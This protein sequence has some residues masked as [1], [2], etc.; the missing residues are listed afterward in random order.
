[1]ETRKDLKI[2]TCGCSREFRDEEEDVAVCGVV[3]VLLDEEAGVVTEPPERGGS[4]L[5][6]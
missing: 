3:I 4:N 5:S 6:R 2:S 1:M